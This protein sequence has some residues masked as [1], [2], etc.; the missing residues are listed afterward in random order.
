[1]TQFHAFHSD[2]RKRKTHL[3]DPQFGPYRYSAKRRSPSFVRG[4]EPCAVLSTNSSTSPAFMK[5]ST[6]PGTRDMSLSAPPLR[7]KAWVEQVAFVAA[8]DQHLQRDKSPHG[9]IQ[10][11]SAST[12]GVWC[13]GGLCSSKRIAKVCLR[14]VP[15]SPAFTSLR[16]T[17]TLSCPTLHSSSLTP[18]EPP[19]ATLYCVRTRRLCAPECRLT[20]WPG[21]R[22]V[23]RASSIYRPSCPA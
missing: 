12:Q 15:P 21:R 5:I 4:A 11:A 2:R 9:E 8:R 17:I 6:A 3:D 10:I 20:P 14:T 22:T 23:T 16:A 1:L 18:S 19:V 13:M 7:G